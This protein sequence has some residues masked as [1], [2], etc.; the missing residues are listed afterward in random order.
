MTTEVVKVRATKIT[1]MRAEGPSDLCGKVH[2]FTGG[3][4]WQEARRHLVLASISAPGH[5]LD[6]H[7]LGYHKTDFTVTWEDGEI[8]SGTLCMTYHEYSIARHMQEYL[9]HVIDNH[10]DY[11]LMGSEIPDV[12]ALRN[13]LST[14]EIGDL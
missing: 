4:V 6:P 7:P 14:Y 5:P 2:E 9:Q 12:D 3:D 8:Y 13:F 10:D 11:V 1:V